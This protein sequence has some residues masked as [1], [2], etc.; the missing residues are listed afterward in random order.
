MSNKSID[1][2]DLLGYYQVLT[3]FNKFKMSERTVLIEEQ[4]EL[5]D[6]IFAFSFDDSSSIQ[7]KDELLNFFNSFNSY[8]LKNMARLLIF[9]VPAILLSIFMVFESFRAF[10]V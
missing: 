9:A 10:R 8:Y 7:L 2:H 3:D 6:R 1:D 5:N 4:T